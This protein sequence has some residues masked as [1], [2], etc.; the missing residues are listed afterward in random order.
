M[1]R[2]SATVRLGN[3]ARPSGTAHRPLRARRSGTGRRTSSPSN[4]DVPGGGGH[5]AARHFEQG[6]LPRPVGAEQRVD[7]S[8]GD[9]ERHAVDDLDA[10]VGG[11]HVDERQHERL[12]RCLRRAGCGAASGKATI[13]AVAC[14]GT[15]GA[16]GGGLD[17]GGGGGGGAAPTVAGRV[18]RA[19]RAGRRFDARFVG[20]A[21]IGG[22][23][24]RV[25]LHRGGVAP[26]DDGAVVEDAHVVADG[27]DEAHVVLHQ[28]HRH[29]PVGEV[30]QH[31]PQLHGLLLV[32]ARARLVE[33]Q[34][35]R[36]GGQR[37][38]EL[39]EAGEARGQQVGGLVGDVRQARRAPAG[40]RPRLR[41]LAPV[42]RCR[43]VS[44]A[45]CTFS[46]AVRVPNS[47]RRWNVRATPSRA[48]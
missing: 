46:R 15:G 44:A 39:D 36:P 30:A 43:L 31:A 41:G 48:R 14:A 19:G 29:A 37:P 11:V 21:E 27:H 42:G 34:H 33:Q 6:G 3:T 1:R 35:R 26:G 12:G 24:G 45:I 47:S 38:A 9:V 40:R 8:V 2:F 20:G 7:R 25:G 17:G 16:G 32:Q 18:P 4:D 13:V 28:Q 10:A 5:A 22:L 23:H